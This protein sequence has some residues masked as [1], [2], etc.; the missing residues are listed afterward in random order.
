MTQ[1][2]EQPEPLIAQPASELRG[3]RAVAVQRFV[4]GHNQVTLYN[5]DCLTLPRIEADAIITDPPYGIA[6]R[7]IG[8]GAAVYDRKHSSTKRHSENIIGD[9]APFDPTPWLQYENVIMWGANNYAD[10]LPPGKGRWLIWDKAEG[11]YEVDSFGDAEIA[12]HSLGKACRIFPYGWKGVY[13]RK[14]GENNGIR[15]HPSMKPVGLMSWC[16]KQSKVPENATILDPY[17]GSGSTGVAC[18][19]AGMNFVGVEIDPKH[20]KTACARLEAECNQ[21]AL[22]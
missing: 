22:L 5:G 10:K 17:M 15:E 8:K 11:R 12:W 19:R 18:L 9:D 3:A 14:A 13:C 16:I 6:Y 21:G 20:F 4:R 7:H 2:A 1:I